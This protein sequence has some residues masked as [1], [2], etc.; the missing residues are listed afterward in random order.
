MAPP[1]TTPTPLGGS[2]PAG[3]LRSRVEAW[4]D[5]DPDPATAAE[6]RALVAAGAWDELADRFA[7]RLEFGTAGLRGA[8]GGGPNRMNVAV[9]RTAS[10]GLAAHLD[11]HGVAGPVVVGRDARHRSDDFAADAAATVAAT[12]RRVLASRSPVPTPVIAYAVRH[13]GAAAGVVV[14][15][16]HNP[17]PDNGYKVYDATGSQIVP[18]TDAEIA[19]AIEAAGPAKDIRTAPE[20]V[21]PLPHEVVDEYVA[22]AARLPAVGDGPRD[23]RIVYTPVHGVGRATVER[24]LAAAGFPQPAVVASQADPDPEF[25]TAPFPNPEEPGVL[26]PAL[27]DARRLGADVVLATDPDA[28]RLAV[29]VPDPVTGEWRRLSGD[30]VGA[31]LGWQCLRRSEGPDRV[32]AASIVSA[33]WLERIAAAFGVPY[34]ATLTGF[35]WVS[36]AGDP[37]GRRLVFGYEEALGYAVSDAVRDKDG[38]TALLA[39]AAVVAELKEQGRT[40]DHLLAELAAEVGGAATAQV[41]LRYEGAVAAET[42]R[43]TMA[44]LRE[45]SPAALGGRAVLRTIDLLA[46]TVVEP[47]GASVPSG[48]PASDVLGWEL[49]GGARVLVRPSG[50]EPKLKCYLEAPL[51]SADATVEALAV[52]R[53]RAA[54][55]LTSLADSVRALLNP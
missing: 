26:D 19:A 47:D 34:R 22:L 18:P 31:I 3:D 55:A 17:A 6:L 38:I 23:V 41:S 2:Q 16:S 42:M 54:E 35:K 46:Q 1:P 24:A 14:T 15:A 37:D 44:G 7:S 49:A 30:D 8:L 39:C 45:R 27:A 29:A 4:I 52:A 40:L 53:A 5:A 43:A 50:T 51:A 10:A 28:D 11:A 21:A 33:R 12:G 48:L 32:V 13:L 20:A 36:R 9:V 25:P